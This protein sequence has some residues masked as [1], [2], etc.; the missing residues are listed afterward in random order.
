M[1]C[2][3]DVINLFDEGENSVDPIWTVYTKDGEFICACHSGWRKLMD[4]KTL[5]YLTLHDVDHIRF[6]PCTTIGAIS[7]VDIILDVEIK[8]EEEPPEVIP[9]VLAALMSLGSND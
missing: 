4:L 1:T 7:T 3:L 2:A 9:G 5:D 8:D 6:N